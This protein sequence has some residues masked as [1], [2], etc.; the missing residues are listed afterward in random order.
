MLKQLLK[1]RVV[2]LSCK[3]LPFQQHVY[4]IENCLEFLGIE[5]K[6]MQIENDNITTGYIVDQSVFFKSLRVGHSNVTFSDGVNKVSGHLFVRPSGEIVVEV[7]SY[8]GDAEIVPVYFRTI[9]ADTVIAIDL[10]GALKHYLVAQQFMQREESISEVHYRSLHPNVLKDSFAGHFVL[11]CHVDGRDIVN[12]EEYALANRQ[13]ALMFSEIVIQQNGTK[14]TVASNQILTFMITNQVFVSYESIPD[15]L[16][17]INV[18]Q[19]HLI[20]V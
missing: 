9:L 1:G 10:K 8:L 4:K 5:I 14:K 6:S 3:E 20:T 18:E 16:R 15:N 19:N 12:A 17:G 7:K 2:T 11:G 13:A